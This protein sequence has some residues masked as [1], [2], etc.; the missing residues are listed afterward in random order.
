MFECQIMCLYMYVTAVILI[1][2][3]FL[4]TYLRSH[5]LYLAGG[6]LTC[7]VLTP[8][9]NVILFSSPGVLTYFVIQP[10]LAYHKI[11]YLG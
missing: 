1:Y 8:P 5:T 9:V 10:G 3:C 7:L 11:N 2:L 4:C 6:L